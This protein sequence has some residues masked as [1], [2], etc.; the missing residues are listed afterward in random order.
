MADSMVLKIEGM[1]CNHC[2]EHVRNAIL[3][4]KGVKSAVVSL[5]KNQAEV[6]GKFDLEA[7]SAAVDEAGYKVA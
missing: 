1:S 2:V 6:T 5:E 3:S 7:I 4:V